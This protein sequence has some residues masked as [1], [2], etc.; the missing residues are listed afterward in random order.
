MGTHTDLR[1][2]QIASALRSALEHR[3]G[4]TVPS[5]RPI[6]AIDAIVRSGQRGERR[7]NRNRRFVGVAT[8]IAVLLGGIGFAQVPSKRSNNLSNPEVAVD[9]IAMPSFRLIPGGDPTELDRITLRTGSFLSEMGGFRSLWADTSRVVSVDTFPASPGSSPIVAPSLRGLIEA[10]PA[11]FQV[12]VPPGYD[13]PDWVSVTRSWISEDGRHVVHL[14]LPGGTTWAE[15]VAVARLVSTGTSGE[16]TAAFRPLGL[17]LVFSGLTS[18]LAPL[19]RWSW[20]NRFAFSLSA[21]RPSKQSLEL[22]R[23][24]LP[25]VGPGPTNE[26]EILVRGQAAKFMHRTIT[27]QVFHARVSWIEDG[28]RVTATASRPPVSQE[29]SV[30]RDRLMSMVENLRP[31]TQAEWARLSISPSSPQR[32]SENQRTATNTVSETEVGGTKWTLSIAEGITDDKCLNISLVTSG[33]DKVLKQCVPLT[34]GPLL[35]SSIQ[36][37][38]GRRVL[39]VLFNETVDS[40]KVRGSAD[41]NEQ[42]VPDGVMVGNLTDWTYVGSMIVPLVSDDDVSIEALRVLPSGGIEPDAPDVDLPP[43]TEEEIAALDTEVREPVPTES[44]GTFRVK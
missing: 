36:T 39:V 15:Q 18:E 12:P 11:G 31:A 23:L 20:S 4:S 21:E 28:W 29:L 34:G 2:E 30:I 27:G 13:Q 9:S 26:E 33:S 35:Y 17:P 19:E 44:L 25:L 32:M 24:K 8:A 38:G 37:G 41:P 1:D 16:V 22:D 40:V 14:T 5:H 42:L 7:R 3:A 43:L 10:G 6:D